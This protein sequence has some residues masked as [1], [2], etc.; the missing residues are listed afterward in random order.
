MLYELRQST[1]WTPLVLKFPDHAY[2]MC[3]TISFLPEGRSHGFAVVIWKTTMPN[4]SFWFILS[5]TPTPSRF[6]TVQKL[7]LSTIHVHHVTSLPQRHQCFPIAFKVKFVRP[8]VVRTMFPFV[9]CSFSVCIL[10]FVHQFHKHL[11]SCLSLAR[12]LRYNGGQRTQ[13]FSVFPFF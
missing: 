8:T 10:C 12:H 11:T 2:F 9:V 6:R 7:G 13:E 5:S 3:W 4:C 1:M